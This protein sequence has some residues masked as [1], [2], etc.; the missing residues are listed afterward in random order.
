MVGKVDAAVGLCVGAREVEDQTVAL[1]SEL[2]ADL[3]VLVALDDV[4]FAPR[5]VGDFRNAFAQDRLG[6]A[7]HVAG[8]AID[9]LRAIFG[10]HL[11]HARLGDV[12][13][14]QSGT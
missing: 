10:V 14:R 6:V 8:D 1:L 9:E 11:L 13:C 7:N 5:A 4:A 3:P 2:D 12:I